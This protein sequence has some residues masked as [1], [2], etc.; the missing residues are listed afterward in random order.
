M[1]SDLVFEAAVSISNRYL[2]ANVIS[3]ATRKMHRPNARLEETSNAV[4]RV[5]AG[6]ASAVRRIY[7]PDSVRLGSPKVDGTS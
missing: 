6:P 5:F 7:S 1:R 3:K 4:L 2:L